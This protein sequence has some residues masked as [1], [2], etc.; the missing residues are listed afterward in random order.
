MSGDR[1]AGTKLCLEK[2][3]QEEATVCG[4]RQ[5]SVEGN[6]VCAWREVRR[7][8]N[9]TDDRSRPSLGC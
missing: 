4:K 3:V 5:L 7:R 9:H 1:Y 8:G 6:C 2:N